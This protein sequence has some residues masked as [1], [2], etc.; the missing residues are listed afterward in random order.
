M[1]FYCLIGQEMLNFVTNCCKLLKVN[2]AAQRAVSSTVKCSPYT[3]SGYIFESFYNVFISSPP[4]R[5]QTNPE[6]S[7]I[8]P[9]HLSE[10]FFFNFHIQEI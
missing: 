1:T 9:N 3:W 2:Q 8:T 5:V 6:M 4:G 7:T 10:F